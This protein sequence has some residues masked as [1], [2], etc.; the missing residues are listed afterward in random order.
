[1]H[2]YKKNQLA[3]YMNLNNILLIIQYRNNGKEM[4][5]NHIEFGILKRQKNLDLLQKKTLEL[6]LILYQLKDYAA[7]CS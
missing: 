1:M 7:N 6:Q 2:K 5:Y 3:F 4:Y